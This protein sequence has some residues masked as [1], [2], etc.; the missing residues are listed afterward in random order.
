MDTVHGIPGSTVSSTNRNE[1]IT[2]IPVVAINDNGVVAEITT[3]ETK[4]MGRER[5]IGIE[6][7]VVLGEDVLVET[8]LFAGETTEVLTETTETSMPLFED[9]GLCFDFTDGFGDNP[10]GHL[11]DDE[12]ALLDDLDLLAVANDLLL[13]GD[14]GLAAAGSVEVVD[15]EEVIKVAHGRDTTP[16]IEGLRSA[17][18]QIIT[19]PDSQ[20]SRGDASHGGESRD[21]DESDLGEHIV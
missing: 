17:R 9:D 12:K 8:D 3:R 13:G 5:T 19:A 14:N 21:E 10:L 1:R 16:V 11:L 7:I 4:V 20:R 2:V 15:T 6:E 18:N